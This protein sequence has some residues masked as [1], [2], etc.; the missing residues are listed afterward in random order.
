[1]P[2]MAV[3]ADIIIEELLV[4][5]KRIPWIL[6]DSSSSSSLEANIGLIAPKDKMK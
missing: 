5:V 6:R 3:M 2:H 4:T 1:M